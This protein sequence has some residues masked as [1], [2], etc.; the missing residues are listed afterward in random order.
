MARL[1]TGRG[2]SGCQLTTLDSANEPISHDE[3]VA[4]PMARSFAEKFSRHRD[5]LIAALRRAGADCFPS[6]E[7][8]RKTWELLVIIAIIYFE[9][10]ERREFVRKDSERRGVIS[11][12]SKAV[13]KARELIEECALQDMELINKYPLSPDYG[14]EGTASWTSV[15]TRSKDVLLRLAEIEAAAVEA[16]RPTR[17]RGRPPSTSAIS[18]EF[19]DALAGPFREYTGK[20]PN[21]GINTD[22]RIFLSAFLHAVGYEW[23]QRESIAAAIARGRKWSLE[24]FGDSPFRPTPVTLPSEI[25]RDIVLPSGE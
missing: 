6:E 15:M 20:I 9:L 16:L 19:V 25:D 1:H 18:D 11:A 7:V 13:R 5:S 4:D 24:N 23:I 21:V 12:A 2:R 10:R 17:A 14:M 3:T 22:F 8:E